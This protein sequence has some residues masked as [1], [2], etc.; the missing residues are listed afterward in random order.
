MLKDEDTAHTIRQSQL[1]ANVVVERVTHVM[2]T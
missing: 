2:D 1:I